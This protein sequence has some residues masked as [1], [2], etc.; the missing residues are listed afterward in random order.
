MLVAGVGRTRRTAGPSGGV[1]TRATQRLAWLFVGIAGRGFVVP[2]PAGPLL[3]RVAG[4]RA[5]SVWCETEKEERTLRECVHGII[6]R[7]GA[8]A[9]QI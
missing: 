9:P 1:Q 7:P 3:A 5:G 6:G 8:G 4:G 2:S